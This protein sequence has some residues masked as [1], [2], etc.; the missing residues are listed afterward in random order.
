MAEAGPVRLEARAKANLRLRVLA[1]EASGFHGVETLLIRLEL[2][3][4]V[5]LE[6][7]DEGIEL[8][9]EEEREDGAAED[10]DGE[11]ATGQAGDDGSEPGPEPVPEGPEN[12]AWRAAEVFFAAAGIEPSV[13]ISLL[14]RIP[15]GAGLGGGSADAAAVLRGLSELHGEPVG[16]ARLFE[17]AG[18]LGSDVP[19]ALSELKAALAWGRGGR[20]IPV[21]PAP[22][23]P[24]AVVVPATRVATPD[25]YGWL[26][27]DRAARGAGGRGPRGGADGVGEAARAE[28]LPDPDLMAYWEVL[29]ELVVNDFEKPVVARIPEIGWWKEELAGEGAAPAVLCGSGCALLGVFEDEERRDAAA[30][31]IEAAGTARV[32]RT[33]GPA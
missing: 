26:D 13:K 5:E 28:L 20:M 15:T 2:A 24:M 33:R 25:A 27:E 1:R 8:S 7:A 23:R 32:L 12:L 21:P 16:D 22:R 17:L 11:A 31:R 6:L 30:D 19:F 18:A 14:K 3:D 4:E 9:L 10:V 29:E